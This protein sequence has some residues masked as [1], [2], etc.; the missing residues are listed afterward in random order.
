[1]KKI[2]GILG[3]FPLIAPVGKRLYGKFLVLPGGPV[4]RGVWSC[5]V[6]VDNTYVLVVEIEKRREAHL[7]QFPSF[8]TFTPH[9]TDFAGTHVVGGTMWLGQSFVKLWT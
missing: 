1:M 3:F 5:R 2:G 9:L 7:I 8:S 6:D 4:L